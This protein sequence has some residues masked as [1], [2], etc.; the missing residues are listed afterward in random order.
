MGDTS[1]RAEIPVYNKKG[2][3][4]NSSIY[5]TCSQKLSEQND[6]SKISIKD[7]DNQELYANKNAIDNYFLPATISE[8]NIIISPN[9]NKFL[10]INGVEKITITIPADFYYETSDGEKISFGTPYSY[11]YIVNSETVD[12]AEVNIGKDTGDILPNGLHN[13]SIGETFDIEYIISEGYYFNNW[14]VTTGNGY[15]GIEIFDSNS[16]ITGI[17]Q[18]VKYDS[19]GNE[20]KNAEKIDLFRFTDPVEDDANYLKKENKIK[21]TFTVLTNYSGILIKPNCM[22]LPDINDYEPKYSTSS[23]NFDTPITITFNKKINT[24]LLDYDFVNIKYGNIDCNSYFI[25]SF[26]IKDDVTVLS[27]KPTSSIKELFKNSNSVVDLTVT[28][29]NKKITDTEG[30]SNTVN[31][32]W[33][34]RIKYEPEQEA[35]VLNLSDSKVYKDIEK[36]NELTNKAFESW[37]DESSDEQEYGDYSQNHINDK[38][39]LDLSFSDNRSGVISVLV[40]ETYLQNVDGESVTKNI[41]KNK[42]IKNFEWEPNSNQ[43]YLFEYKLSSINDGLIK[44]EFFIQDTS[45]NI[46]EEKLI[47]YVIKDTQVYCPDPLISNISS[48]TDKLYE[49]NNKIEVNA[50][51]NTIEK[52][53]ESLKKININL[54]DKWFQVGNK[55]FE[56]LYVPDEKN[57]EIDNSN[58]SNYNFT[59][60]EDSSNY[61]FSFTDYDE[62]IYTNTSIT[63]N[64]TD[65]VGNK[66]NYSIQLPKRNYILGYTKEDY[67]NAGAEFY[68]PLDVLNYSHEIN[69]KYYLYNKNSSQNEHNY[70]LYKFNNF[71]DFKLNKANFTYNAYYLDSFVVPGTHIFILSLPSNKIEL[72]L[73]TGNCDNIYS[74]DYLDESNIPDFNLTSDKENSITISLKNNTD[75]IYF[76]NIAEEEEQAIN[77]NQML[78]YPGTYEI[79]G[80]IEGKEYFISPRYMDNNE[81]PHKSNV[82]KNIKIFSSSNNNNDDT[83]DHTPPFYYS[84]YNNII[85]EIDSPIKFTN[86]LFNLN[87]SSI[88]DNESLKLNNGCLDVE[89]L[90]YPCYPGYENLTEQEFDLLPNKKIYKANQNEIENGFSIISPS[91]ETGKYFIASRFY[92]NAGNYHFKID[93]LFNFTFEKNGF[94]VDKNSNSI[95]LSFTPEDNFDYSISHSKWNLFYKQF[96]IT[97]N[98]WETINQSKLSPAQDKYNF[99]YT[100]GNIDT[101]LKNS[102]IYINF[103]V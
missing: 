81:I 74:I 92:D 16:T 37:S 70:T 75:N 56:T 78:V 42:I 64:V 80:D 13:Y 67:L 24:N 35:P 54:Y 28:I 83:S 65:L 51:L 41:C 69:R 23:E 71:N 46:C 36:K 19:F 7:E 17:I 68:F 58:S 34:Y 82:T 101:T 61:I 89:Y 93:Q 20:D 73:E 12:K 100:I 60:D 76:F 6:V 33:Q 98:N 97:T 66:N 40:N 25:K 102:F 21:R 31:L 30:K 53:E 39:Y 10:D 11:T 44:L 32:S 90:F 8:N 38:V 52:I 22:Q 4:K 9:P 91:F 26:S 72:N 1:Y 95:K 85:F 14:S 79:Q 27:L 55:N 18:L 43:N 94:S 86:D 103:A 96:N 63:F 48:L 45:E 49:N 47:Y 15:K 50:Y 5:L 88:T 77:G 59:Y 87:F 57:F 29:D 3:P 2:V 84:T 99:S 62:N